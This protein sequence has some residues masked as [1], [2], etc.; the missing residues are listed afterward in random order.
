MISLARNG[1]ERSV[2]F[3]ASYR[4]GWAVD[5]RGIDLSNLIP[6]LG[7]FTFEG[8]LILIEIAAVVDVEQIGRLT[9]PVFKVWPQRTME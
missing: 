4:R 7:V 9:E 3:N 8:G 5:S 6:E 1:R 2:P